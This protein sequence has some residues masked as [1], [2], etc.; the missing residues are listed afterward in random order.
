M[1]IN[2]QLIIILVLASLLFSS[3]AAA[4]YFYKKN[5]K[6]LKNSNELI[7]V[8]IAKDDIPKGTFLETKHLAKTQIAKQFL[9]NK[10]LVKKEILG[11][12]SSETIYK[13]EIFLKQK[14]GIKKAKRQKE[15]LEFKH[16]S[17]NMSFSLFENPNYTLK[18]G[19]YINIISVYGQGSLNKK[20]KY[21]NFKVQYIAKKIKVLGFLRDG[22]IENN[23]IIK[24]KIKK[25]VKKKVIEEEQDV[26]TNELIVDIQTNTLLSLIKDYNKGNQLWM[27]K[28]K[29]SIEEKIIPILS[30]KKIK[31]TYKKTYPY[32]LYKGENKITTKSAYINYGDNNKSIKKD[33]KMLTDYQKICRN[34]KYN[35]VLGKANSFYIRDEPSTKSKE[36][37]LLDKNTIIPYLKKHKDWYETCDQKYVHKNV[38]ESISSNEVKVKLGGAKWKQQKNI[39]KKQ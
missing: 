17:Y 35:F 6:V 4:F 5:Q 7:T 26:K 11:K 12:Y 1:Q 31:K 28:T 27:V 33:F 24:Q 39:W 34:I 13:H 32:I 22:H 36:K 29:E 16:N 14:L 19:D 30:I 8:Y 10:P 3:L 20:G 21:K 37:K 38:V 9:L 25:I 18:R 2:R 23:T 15:L